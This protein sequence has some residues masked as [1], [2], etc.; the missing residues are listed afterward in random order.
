M[1]ARMRREDARGW[2]TKIQPCFCW[3]GGI[4]ICSITGVSFL[5]PDTGLDFQEIELSCVV[6]ERVG[7]GE[8][9]DH[10]AWWKPSGSTG[11][12]SWDFKKVA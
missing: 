3:E 11:V 5:E 4:F 7:R 1:C 12:D 9:S 6:G 10:L 8:R 2:F